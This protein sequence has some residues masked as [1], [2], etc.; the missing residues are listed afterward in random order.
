MTYFRTR[1]VNGCTAL[2][3]AVCH[4]VITATVLTHVQPPYVTVLQ[5]TMSTDRPCNIA[6]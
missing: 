2:N 3:P 1:R 4:S 5:Y 6:L